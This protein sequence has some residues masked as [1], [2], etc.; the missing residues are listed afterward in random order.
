MKILADATLPGLNQAFPKPFHLTLYQHPD[1]ITQLLPG[2]EVLLCRSTLKVNHSL[3]KS[4][5][6]R[7]I[8]TASSGR[9]HLDQQWLRSQNIQIIDAKGSNARSVADYVVSCLAY[10]DQQQ[11]ISGNKA[12]IIGLGMV[13][14]QVAT[15]LQALNF[16]TVAYDPLKEMQEPA[17]ESCPIEVLHQVDLL[18]LHAELHDNQPYPSMN[19]I[20]KQ[21]LAKLKPGCIII[22]A[23]RGGI[24]NEEELLRTQQALT[25]CTDVYLNEPAIDKRIIDKAILCTP[26]IAGHSLEAKYLAVAMISETLH[27]IAGLPLPQFATPEM[28]GI[29]RLEKDMTWQES[30]L[31][32]YNPLN[33]TLQLK[34][35]VDKESAFLRLRK[36]HQQRH[37]FLLYF[38]GTLN[39]TNSLFNYLL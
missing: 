36:S 22:N 30:V 16:Q 24:I 12:G 31:T 15:R 28:T 21:F 1:E 14:V 4:H 27:H 32:I 38:N 34:E 39:E 20:D 19:L 17:F 9:D 35:A 8:A 7:F 3:L 23:A 18:C 25:Y 2:Q 13:G 5:Q 10:L 37:D 6:V 11:L 26:H 29:L 33:E